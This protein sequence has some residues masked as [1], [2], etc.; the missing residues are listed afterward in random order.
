MLWDTSK[1]MDNMEKDTAPTSAA[2]I[3]AM[4]PRTLP[5]ALA[6]I[7]MGSFLAAANGQ[8]QL[9]V[10]LLCALT[11]ILLQILSN[12]ANDYG[13]SEHGADSVQRVGP[14]RAV[15]SGNIS[16][17]AMLGAMAATALLATISGLALLWMAFTVANTGVN[18]AANAVANSA[19]QWRTILLFVL[20]G[21]IAIWAA[22]QY[23]AGKNPYG[24]AGFGDLSV[25]LFFGWLGVLG[26]YFLQANALP[27]SLFWPATSC[28]LLA[29]AV[30]NI[31][32]I[33]DIESDRIAG[34]YSI[35]VRLGR[36]RA[37]VYHWGLLLCAMLAAFF[38]VWP[39]FRT[40][41]SVWTLLFFVIIIPLLFYNGL[42]V[43]RTASARLDPYLKQMALISL[44]FMLLFGIGQLIG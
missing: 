30:L 15:Q 37:I 33:R 19:I 25:L 6:S 8:F 32:N 42:V 4:R 11:T 20:L 31:N 22:I 28:G 24:Y 35:P 18:A 27:L 14:Q 16:R 29:V 40:G 44:L 39:R 38:Y 7:G 21:A 43:T 41:A 23:T 13:D 5:L 10:A 12:L 34:K 9:G 36:T 3:S 26:T 2:W 1:L 17:R